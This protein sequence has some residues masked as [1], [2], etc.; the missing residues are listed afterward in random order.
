MDAG[1]PRLLV[2]NPGPR[3][4]VWCHDLGQAHQTVIVFPALTL[5]YCLDT[6]LA[7]VV[8]RPDAR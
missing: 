7:L 4:E 3:L 6:I 2:A 8:S 5:G 1:L